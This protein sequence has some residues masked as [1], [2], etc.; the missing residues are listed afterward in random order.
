VDWIEV[1]GCC[2]HGNEPSFF[3]TGKEFVNEL[4]DYFSRITLQHRVSLLVSR[5]YGN[6]TKFGMLG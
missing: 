3:L 1:A 5:Y 2:E 6:T 4:S